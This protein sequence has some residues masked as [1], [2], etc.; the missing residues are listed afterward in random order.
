MPAAINVGPVFTV[1]NLTFP[2]RDVRVSKIRAY[3]FWAHFSHYE[4]VFHFKN[5]NY[6]SVFRILYLKYF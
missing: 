4:H 2:Y 1:A 5:T 6:F 3:T